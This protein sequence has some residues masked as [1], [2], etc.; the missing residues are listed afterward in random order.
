MN[1]G[2][3]DYQFFAAVTRFQ[4]SRK[5]KNWNMDTLPTWLYGFL[6][7]DIVLLV[8]RP[9]HYQINVRETGRRNQE[10]II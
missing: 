10:Y 5:L 7:E 4:H 8:I 1:S 9:I 3:V 2:N 6:F